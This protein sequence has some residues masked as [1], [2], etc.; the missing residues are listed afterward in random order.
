MLEYQ[1]ND[2]CPQVGSG[3][4]CVQVVAV[5]Q[6]CHRWGRKTFCGDIQVEAGETL[7]ELDVSCV[8]GPVN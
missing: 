5:V 2:R 7:D 6:R 8:V 1:M 3:F 4:H